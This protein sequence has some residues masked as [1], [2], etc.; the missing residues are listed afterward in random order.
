MCPQCADREAEL[1]RANERIRDLEEKVQRLECDRDEV[2]DSLVRIR[3][4][5]VDTIG[6]Y[7]DEG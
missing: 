3:N 5:A 7:R 4:E 2:V 1:E 6:K